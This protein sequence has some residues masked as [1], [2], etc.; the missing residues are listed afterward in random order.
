VEVVPFVSGDQ[1]TTIS[2]SIEIT[3]AERA[4]IGQTIGGQA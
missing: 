1:G 2:E 3:P 4:G